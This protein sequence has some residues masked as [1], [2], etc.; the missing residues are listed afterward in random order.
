MYIHTQSTHA[1]EG[2]RHAALQVQQPDGPLL[3]RPHAQPHGRRELRG[4]EPGKRRRSH[5]STAVVLCCATYRAE[6][7][8]NIH[9]PRHDYLR[10][11]T[12]S[13]YG[14]DD[15]YGNFD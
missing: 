12:A 5:K 7:H 6:I 10:M 2:D 1:V 8:T 9:T 15:G 13:V 14:N 3:G 11:E 4:Q